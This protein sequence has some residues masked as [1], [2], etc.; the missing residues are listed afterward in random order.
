MLGDFQKSVD[1]AADKIV[2]RMDMIDDVIED[3]EN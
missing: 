2:Q 3:I 1:R